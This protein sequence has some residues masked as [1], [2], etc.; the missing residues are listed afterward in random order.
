MISKYFKETILGEVF[1]ISGY[2]N[3]IGSFYIALGT[4]ATTPSVVS[5]EITGFTE[6]SGNGYSRVE[7]GTGDLGLKS[8]G[9]IHNAV[10][11]RFSPSTG[12]WSG[13]IK[14]WALFGKSNGSWVDN[15]KPLACGALVSPSERTVESGTTVI[16]RSDA[17]TFSINDSVS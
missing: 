15:N 3:G 2:T 16:I 5:G 6:Q 7:L 14:Y 11:I 10:A 8:D 1:N 17:L 13:K 4:N 9:T 12:A